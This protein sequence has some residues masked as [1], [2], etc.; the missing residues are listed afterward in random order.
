MGGLGND[1]DHHTLAELC[2]SRAATTRLRRD[3]SRAQIR[4]AAM[5]AAGADDLV[6]LAKIIKLYKGFAKH[7]CALGVF[8]AG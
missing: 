3:K 2:F 1:D 6:Y 8:Y 7:E 4:I 5:Y